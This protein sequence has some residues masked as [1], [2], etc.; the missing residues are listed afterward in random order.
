MKA[1]NKIFCAVIALSLLL[2]IAANIILLNDSRDNGREYRVEISRL[3]AEIREKGFESADLS[4]CKYVTNIQKQSDNFYNAESDYIIREIGGELYRFDYL[5]NS[6]QD[7]SNVLLIVNIFIGI[8]LLA[9]IAVL[10]FIRQKILVP[11]E[12]ISDVPYQLSKGNLSVPLKESR[13][14]FFGKFV[15]GLDML[16]ETLEQQKRKELQLQKEKK[17]LLLS[18]SHDIKTP[19]SAIKLYSKALSTG[20]YPDIEKQREISENINSKADEIESYV[21]RIIGASREDFLSLEVNMGEFYISE[22]IDEIEKYYNEKLALI[23][24]ELCIERFGNCLIKGDIDRSCEVFQNIIENA[25]KYGD[26]KR[27]SIDFSEEEGCILISVKNGGCTLSDTELPHIFE[28]FW[29]GANAKS[30]EGAGLG[31]YICRQL[32]HKM[33]GEA[34]AEISSDIFSITTVF[35]KA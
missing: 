10:L 3:E 25:V 1:F 26:G 6:E 18:L 30:K 17:T 16:R 22:L 11:F 23:G 2:L 4:G 8:M 5:T 34:F 33:G 21:S 29:R 32:M 20:L 19:L 31:L 12:E 13:S 24:A 28:S 9:A 15:W 14:R 35:V 7:R 27:I